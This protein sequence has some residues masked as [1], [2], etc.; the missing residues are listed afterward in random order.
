VACV[1]HMVNGTVKREVWTFKTTTTELLALAEWL[2]AEKCTHIGMAATG[3]L[4]K[5]V[6]RCG[7]PR[8]GRGGVAVNGHGFA[9][10]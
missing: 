1:R 8:S 3:A 7:R 10:K 9:L 5:R 4:L 6:C 2:A